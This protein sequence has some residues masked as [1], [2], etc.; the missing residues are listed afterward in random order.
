MV[1]NIMK[2]HFE[3]FHDNGVELE[4]WDCKDPSKPDF[5]NDIGS[6]QFVFLKYIEVLLY[7]YIQLCK[8]RFLVSFK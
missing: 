4:P 6:I 8:L 7:F 1:K 5:L 3:G 2:S